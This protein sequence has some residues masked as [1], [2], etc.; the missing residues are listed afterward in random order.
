MNTKYI[1]KWEKSPLSTTSR[2]GTCIGFGEKK[3]FWN[4]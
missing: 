4:C 1:V 2:N 3:L